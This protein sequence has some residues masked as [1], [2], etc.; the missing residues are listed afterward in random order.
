[1][2]GRVAAGPRRSSARSLTAG[3]GPAVLVASALCFV[4][5]AALLVAALS[6]GGGHARPRSNAFAGPTMPPGLH[7][8]G[9]S[10][11]DQDGRTVRLSALRGRVVAIA[12]LHSLCRSTCPV[13]V[14]TMRGALDDLGSA[15]H[16]VT[17]LGVSVAPSEDT[18][19]HV[20]RF[21]SA[22]HARGFLRY[23]T[24]SRTALRAVWKGYGVHPLTAHED[25]TAY[26][27]LVD[28][29]G[30]ERVGWPAHQMTPEGLAHDLRILI[31][32]A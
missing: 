12:F 6:G 14:Q 5:S 18:P 2:S 21:V 25:H 27:F 10:L 31:R 30:I 23:L 24:G 9:F 22:Q 29:H 17:A 1:M 26:V 7:A 32:S 8:T 20:R 28:R 13:T 3:R 16:E 4:A 11:T 15:R 19:T